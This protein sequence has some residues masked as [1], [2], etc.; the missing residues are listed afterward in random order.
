MLTLA[1][2]QTQMNKGLLAV[3][4]GWRNELNVVLNGR[5]IDSQHG[6]GYYTEGD[7]CRTTKLQIADK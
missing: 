3:S 7:V 5:L 6:G 2:S 4:F 1:Q